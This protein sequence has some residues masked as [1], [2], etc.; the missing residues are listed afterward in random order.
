[1]TADSINSSEP[2][3]TEV[4]FQTLA[5]TSATLDLIVFGM[6]S[7]LFGPLLV[8]LAHR[9]HLSLAASGV[10]LSVY[11]VGA[12]FG[13]PIGWIAMRRFT[14]AAVLSGTLVI[15]ALGA[16]GAALATQWAMFLVSVFLL[17]LGFGGVDFSLISLLVRTR[18][19]GR[20]RRLSVTNAGYGLGAVIGPLLVVVVRPHNYR[21][22][23]VAIA[24]AVVVL[25][26]GNRGLIAPPLSREHRRSDLVVNRTQRRAIL[27]TF[28]GAYVFYV[29]TETTTAGWIAPH[30]HRIGYS[31]SLG[32]IITAGFWLGLAIGRVLAGPLSRRHADRRL[33]LGGLAA[34]VALCLVALVTGAA[35]YVY[36]FVGLSI[37]LVYPLALVW[38]STLCPHDDDGV[39][40]LILC[41]MAGG[42]IGPAVQ[43]LM[44]SSF[45]IRVVPIVLA[46]FAALTLATFASALRFSPPA[47]IRPE[48][49]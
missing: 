37:A 9:F 29:A 49:D 19:S 2:S 1:V 28:I 48:I 46:S 18:T 32:S 14:G 39:A 31:A 27:A 21:L 3:S 13:V 33:V 43:S 24:I 34:A 36:P 16:C 41:M 26:L 8:T 30:L 20:G 5:L 22:L 23:Y 10:V 4:T 6:I 12:F 38:Y 45:G 47:T 11:F 42:V 35:P 17:G 40:L 15:T 44:V 7:S 25:T